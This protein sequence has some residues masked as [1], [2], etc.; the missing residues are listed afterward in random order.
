MQHLI[1]TEVSVK[2]KILSTKDGTKTFSIIKEIDCIEGGGHG[3]FILLYP[4]R[5][6]DNA[7]IEDSTNNHILNHMKELG[8]K[9][10]TIINL[11]SKVT[12]SRLS[13]SG[14][15]VDEE[16][17]DFIK[18]QVFEN[19]PENSKVV[20]AWGNANQASPVVCQSKQRILKLWDETQPSRPLYQ[21][22]V[23][24]LPKDN[25]GVHPLYL[26]IRYSQACWKLVDYPHK[27]VLQQLN[28]QMEAKKAKGNGSASKAGNEESTTKTVSK[29]GKGKKNS[30][31]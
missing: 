30:K 2:T 10:Y 20:I 26:G 31:G 22:T 13:L 25:I 1:S 5:T 29:G 21:M 12:Q 24:G 16:N 14:L 28:A 9:S 6:A 23:E 7:Y 8:L 3:Y 4:T 18:E 15:S 17:M 27:K 11:F 19:L